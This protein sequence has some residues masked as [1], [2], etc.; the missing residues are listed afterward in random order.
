MNILNLPEF[1]VIDTIQ[2]EHDMTV[3]VKPVKEPLACPE[4]GG[5]EYYKHGKSKRFVR[6]L[7][8]FGKRV[9][10]EIHTNRY[11]CKY[12]N[13]TFSQHYESID[14]R[15][16]IT[17]RLR[18]QIERESLKKPFANIAEEY[19][20]SPTTVKRIFENYV[21]E[22]E[23]DLDY[24]TP[25]IL[26]IDEAHLNKNMRAVYTDI[27]GRKVLDIQP[28]RKKSDVKA[29]LNKL[30]N[31]Y[32][33]E[34]VT[35]DM[36]RYYKEAVYEVLPNAMVIVDKFHVIQLVTKALESERKAF[37]ATLDAKRRSKLLKER[38]LLLRNHEDLEARDIWKLEIIFAE[39]PQLKLAYELKEQ[40]RQIYK[41]ENKNDAYNAYLEWKASIPEDMKYY[42]EVA[43][44][45]DNWKHEIFNYFECNITNAYTESVNNLIKNIEKAGR[46]YSFEVLRAKVLFGT[47]ATKK[48]KYKRVEYQ[49]P[50]RIG[51]FTWY[52]YITKTKTIIEE[53]FGVDIPQLLEVLE[54]DKF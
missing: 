32:D 19:S 41:Y 40:F 44:T 29:F 33:I 12:C 35:I 45:V 39:F 22:A 2:D 42:Q 6:D 18:E 3:I 20:I 52:G 34:V 28:S 48:P 24:T 46:G 17:I 51:K 38:F 21:K 47:S 1:E 36:W 13:S 11:K 16:K 15:D 50:N 7:N 9:G 10:I 25:I 43:K 5:V 54:S 23:K 31:K 8:S 14:D 37:R 49:A 30:P 27:I 26:G 53:G 4:C